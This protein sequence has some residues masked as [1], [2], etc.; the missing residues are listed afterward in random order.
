[1]NLPAWMTRNSARARA[2]K[3]SQ[4]LENAETDRVLYKHEGWIIFT[5]ALVLNLILAYF[6]FFVWHIGNSD[7]LSHTANAFY[8][9]YSREPHLAAVG[10]V[11]PPLPSF[12][13]L[14]LLPLTKALGIVTFTGSFISALSGAATLVL[15]D[16]MLANFR[17]SAFLRWGL[18][19]LLQFH[20]D[21][22]YLSASGM[23]EPIFLFFAVAALYGMTTV[24]HSMRSWVIVGISLALSFFIR[25]EALAM[26]AG[27]GVAIIVHLWASGS[28]WRARTEGWLLAVLTPPVYGIALWLF[29]NWTLMG[30]PLYFLRSVYSL[31]N[32][33][34]IAKVAGLTH[35]LYLAW[36]NMVEA[37]KVGGMRSFQ[38]SPAYPLMAV[39][40]AVSIAFHRDRKGFGLFI[41]MLSVTAFTILQ[42]YLGSLANWL[43][44][45]F[46]AAPFGLIMAGI[47]YEKLKRNWRVPFY[48]LLVVAF[49]AGTPLSLQAMRST[50]VGGDEQ[51]LSALILAP[52]EEAGLRVK[53]GY[54]V[55]L[56]DAPIVAKVVDEYSA[57]GLV[58]VDSSSS[59]SVIMS[60][61]A[62]QRLYISNDTGYFKVLANP[63][64]TVKYLLVL[65]PAT[66]GAVNTINIT[67]P[68]LFESG[69]S[70]AT[71]AWDS[72]TQT[73]N[74]WRI[75]AIHS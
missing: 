26:T 60:V 46:Y 7:A 74:H 71:L 33:P 9:L 18:L 51:R 14:P 4:P 8:V 21:T 13:Q 37:I 17:F 32:A 39:L 1:M 54:W 70:W 6:L 69:A 42:V 50:Q 43:R 16:R 45:W 67:Y 40:A 68:T 15:L 24:P 52:Q 31:S 23:A 38:Q 19:L 27:V 20:P 2:L 63:V 5:L 75:Y 64:G 66:E 30:D 22:W 55:Y 3:P 57:K 28:D 65:D 72:G 48:V 35:P 41:V 56:H 12:L 36:G 58:L 59:F 61:Q 49:L 25:Y 47:V 73:I 34:D 10:F 44:Y 62:P 53:D 29:F 11:W